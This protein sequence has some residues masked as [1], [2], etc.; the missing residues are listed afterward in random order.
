[1]VCFFFVCEAITAV[2][3]ATSC[4]AQSAILSPR[5]SSALALKRSPVP[6][7]ASA[8][9]CARVRSRLDAWVET[10]V[11]ALVLAAHAAYENDGAEQ[12]YERVVKGTAETIRECRLSDDQNFV[13]HYR[14]FVGYV[15]A[16]DIAQLR[17]HE[18][19][20]LVPDKQYFE[21]T[22]QYVQVPE[23]LLAQNFLHSVSRHE[24]LNEAKSFLRDLNSKRD[25]GDQLIFFSYRSQ[26]LGTPDNDDS[27]ERLLIVVPGNVEKGLPEK[28]VQFGV[29]DR[30]ARIHIRNLSV[31]STMPGPNGASDVYFKD[32]YRTY[33]RDEPIT[34]KGRWELGYGDDNCVRCHKS[35]VL[36]VFPEPGSVSAG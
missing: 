1:M 22:R 12:R 19:G 27:Y 17:D 2:I 26:H 36:P 31:V 5:Y 35:G 7:S 3:F 9:S 23:F 8:T 28:W 18:L 29:T 21:E 10:K 24:T 25:P 16:A 33:R 13:S 11:D 14:E 15:E 30:G 32:F 6:F 34:I 20:F 4:H